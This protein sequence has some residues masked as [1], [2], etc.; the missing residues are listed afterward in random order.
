[1]TETPSGRHGPSRPWRER[2]FWILTAATAA[3]FAWPLALGR[4]YFFRDLYFWSFPQRARLA[5]LW[6]A[7][8]L[9]L[10]DRLVYGGQPLLPNVQYFGLYPTSVLSLVLPPVAAVNVEIVLHFTLAAAAAYALARTVGAT[11]AASAA[12][13]VVFVFCGAT[14]SLGNLL[15]RLLATPHTA[16]LLLFWHRFL[17]EGRRRWFVLAAAAGA[18]QIFA[19]SAEQLVFSGLLAAAWGIVYPYRS[20][21]G[22]RVRRL[23][24]AAA[25]AVAIFGLAAVQILPMVELVRHSWRGAGLPTSERAIWSVD[26]RRLPELV[27]P[28]F[29]G[30]TDTLRESDYWGGTVEDMGFPMILSFYFGAAALGLAIAGAAAREGPL[31]RGA[32]RVLAGFLGG[33]VVL[34]LG[35]FL[36]RM[37]PFDAS[38]LLG[39]MFRY[40]VKFF[41]AAPLPAALLAANGA[42]ALARSPSAARRLAL[43]LAAATLVLGGVAALLARRGDF[44]AAFGRAFFRHEATPAIASALAARFVWAA[45]AAGVAALLVAAARRGPVAARLPAL[46]AVVLAMDLAGAG[47]RVNPSAPD[48]LLIREPPLAGAVR[49]LLRDGRFF[50]DDNP[51]NLSLD[52]PSNEIRWRYDWNRR[53]LAY[54]TAA[55]FGIPQIFQISADGL[56]LARHERLTEALRRVPWPRRL[57]ILSAASVRVF[58]TPDA[59]DAPGVRL[60]QELRAGADR[61]FRLYANDRAAARATLPEYWRDVR[62]PEEAVRAM[63]SPGFDPTRHAAI[64]GG[65][66]RPPGACGGGSVALLRSSDAAAE[67]RVRSTCAGY[68]V[69]SEPFAPG[70]RATVDGAAAAVLPANVL[71]SAVAV[72]AGEHVVRRA[73]VPTRFAGGAAISLLT[74]AILLVGARR[75]RV[76]PPR[77]A[78]ADA[79]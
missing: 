40:P 36:P 23:G 20:A 18:L 75:A 6:K 9:P 38:V 43:A 49:G 13:G 69:V 16:L 44:A 32:R 71:F 63:L 8:T 78:S 79:A 55:G 1:M 60:V 41:F 56:D 28:G 12:A 77:T 2:P 61:P 31:P 72:P 48:E 25:L 39:G 66:A 51:K 76:R 10:W 19:A 15:A 58:L 37:G 73:Y 46:L 57:P 14:L 7:G 17:A 29:F 59:V 30:D 45:A 42:D 27:V 33:A 24:L 21:A 67:W 26:P 62:S 54:Y 5:A 35:R 22:G 53:T 68:L 64:E 4:T 3:Y 52:A 50:R 74:A 70:W 11:P 47:R 65:A 34:A